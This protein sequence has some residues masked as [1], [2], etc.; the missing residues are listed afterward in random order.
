MCKISDKPM[1]V[2]GCGIQQLAL[3][4]SNGGKTFQLNDN[5]KLDPATGDV[6]S[7]L[8]GIEWKHEGNVGLHFSGFIGHNQVIK[9]TTQ[10]LN[11]K[12]LIQ[13]VTETKCY[14]VTNK[15]PHWLV[16]GLPK[17]FAANTGNQWDPN[18]QT[19][20]LNIHDQTVYTILVENE[21][22]LPVVA[23]HR[24]SCVT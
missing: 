22:R 12:I 8:N 9:A 15:A 4:C 7:N 5:R 14:V 23:I 20:K 3:Y 11:K 16:A 1:L 6:F 10:D 21:K 13:K 2:T 19:P 17:F 18:P 24:K